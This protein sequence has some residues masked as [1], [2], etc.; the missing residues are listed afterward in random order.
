MRVEVLGPSSH[1]HTGHLHLHLH[2]HVTVNNTSRD[3]RRDGLE[4][5]STLRICTATA[6][7]L[8]A[9]SL[10]STPCGM[11]FLYYCYCAS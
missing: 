4:D 7:V 2:L 3:E 1:S 5:E 9:S 11:D 6:E 8:R 10:L